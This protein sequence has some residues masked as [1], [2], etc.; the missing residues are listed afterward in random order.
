MFQGTPKNNSR[1]LEKNWQL[2]SKVS[3]NCRQGRTKNTTDSFVKSDDDVISLSL[4][5]SSSEK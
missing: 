3:G 4:S 5:C 2:F 1:C